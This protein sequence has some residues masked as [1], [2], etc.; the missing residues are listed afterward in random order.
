VALFMKSLR[1][2]L[3]S[4]ID[5][6]LVP[7]NFSSCGFNFPLYAISVFSVV[8]EKALVTTEVTKIA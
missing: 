5:P 4:D 8:K 1:E 7:L 2:F 6:P 3:F